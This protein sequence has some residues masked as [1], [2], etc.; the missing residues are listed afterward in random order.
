MHH[1]GT[2]A[3]RRRARQPGLAASALLGILLGLL[4]AGATPVHAANLAAGASKMVGFKVLTAEGGMEATASV[5][6]A[7]DR[8]AP[9]QNLPLPHIVFFTDYYLVSAQQDVMVM[10]DAEQAAVVVL[11][12][13]C[14][15]TLIA[16]ET[17]NL[18]C[19]LAGYRYL[20][21]YR[22]ERHIDA[23]LDAMQFM[24]SQ[25]RYNQMIG[26]ES[27]AGLDGRLGVIRTELRSALRFAAAQANGG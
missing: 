26:R 18:K 21:K 24:T 5:G 25:F 1:L 14:P 20:M 22:R 8:I 16:S 6:L 17:L 15:D 2:A 9:R 4:G 23:L 10:T 19:D 12:D 7:G 13:A 3:L 11:L 27:Q